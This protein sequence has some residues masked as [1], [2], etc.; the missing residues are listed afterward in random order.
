DLGRFPE[1]VGRR[2]AA[3]VPVKIDFVDLHW[4]PGGSSAS[5]SLGKP[6]QITDALYLVRQQI[7]RY[8]GGDA[9]RIGLSLTETNVGVG[10]NT[11]PGALYLADTYSS[12]LEQ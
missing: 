9:G 1:R 10:E 6:A 5:D 12:L 11:Q 8:A 4:Y 3:R 7:A 2:A